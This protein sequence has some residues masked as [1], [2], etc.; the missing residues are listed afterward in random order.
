MSIGSA[1]AIYFVMWWVV[2]FITL[3]FAMRSQAEMDDVTEGTEP[4][5]PHDPQLARRFLVNTVLTSVVF[6]LYY[7]VF[8]AWG[9]SIM[10]LPRIVPD[11]QR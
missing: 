10:D 5:A 1:L 2:L 3:P 6:G 8:Y 9:Y 7:L 4:G 11:R